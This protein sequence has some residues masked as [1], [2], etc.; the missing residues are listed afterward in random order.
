MDQKKLHKLV[1]GIASRKFPSE[2]KLLIHVLGQ[3]IENEDISVTGGRIWKLDPQDGT[4]KII[5]QQG[6]SKKLS[7]GFKLKI[8]D[9]PL[10]DIIA[11]ERTILGDETN[12]ELRNMGIF[13]YS[14]SGVGSKIKLNDL[15]YYEFLI[16]LN[17]DV[18]GEE[19]RIN[20]NIIATALTSQIKQ[21]R[22]SKSASSL[23]ADI[24]RARQI[25]KSILPEHEHRYGDYE[26]YGITNPA[27]IVSGD[28]FDYI[29]AGEEGERL[30]IAIGD[31]A[32]KG[33]GAAAEAMYVSGALRMATGFEIKIVALMRRM[34]QLVNKI[35]EDD[36]F[37]SLFYGELSKQKSGMFLYANAG[38]NPPL[39]YKAD[40]GNVE[41]LEITG[42][43]LGPAPNANYYI[44]SISFSEGDVLL[45]YSDG[46][47][48]TADTKF[49]QYGEERLVK[50]LK[51]FSNQSS[52]QLVLSILENV[53]KFSQNGLYEDDKTLV[54]IKR[55]N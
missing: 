20:L 32:S 38:H 36:K 54:A 5:Y 19:L 3:I 17:S 53:L 14:A 10:F 47:I 6:S 15:N 51:Q 4:Y 26:I 11:K 49:E 50:D 2:E 34:N 33:V 23:K 41:I 1:E 29:E 27:E 31:A 43:L 45:L 8:S 35:F 44:G 16:A 42:P 22:Y 13:R 9:Y 55:I 52:K 28:F 7:R 37:S 39:F 21:R 12:E 48:E 46:I 25:Q 24:D 30:G 18:I 40:T